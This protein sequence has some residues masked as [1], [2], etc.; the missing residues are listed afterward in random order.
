MLLTKLLITTCLAI[1]E[2]RD[3]EN[4]ERKARNVSH[5]VRQ[6]RDLSPRYVQDTT[7]RLF[8][9][10]VQE[11]PTHACS[12]NSGSGSTLHKQQDSNVDN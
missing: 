3:L 5:H 9:K 11:K 10:R 2:P 7:P 8:D 4:H 1:R 6:P 12:Q